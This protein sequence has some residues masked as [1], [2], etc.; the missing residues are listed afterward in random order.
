MPH[1]RRLQLDRPYKSVSQQIYMKL[2]LYTEYF[3]YLKSAILK[4]A[5]LTNL[6]LVRL[7]VAGKILAA[8]QNPTASP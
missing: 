7:V 5:F 6:A 2:K 1:C 4:T 8:H 3:Y